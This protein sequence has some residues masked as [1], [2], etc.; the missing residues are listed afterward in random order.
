[1]EITAKRITLGSNYIFC[2]LQLLL[3]YGTYGG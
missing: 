3:N 1:M 2:S